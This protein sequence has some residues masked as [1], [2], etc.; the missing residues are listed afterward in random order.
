MAVF[1]FS[2]WSSAGSFRL[3]PVYFILNFL[4]MISESET[5]ESLCSDAT[6]PPSPV[7]KWF[8]SVDYLFTVIYSVSANGGDVVPYVRVSHT[9][10]TCRRKSSDAVFVLP[11]LR[12]SHL[13]VSEF[14]FRSGA[15]RNLRSRTALDNL[16]QI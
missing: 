10:G 12:S 16:P 6:P 4:Y 1:F 9:F 13:Y 3:V 8:H 15:N 2:S 14:T 11:V 5:G 7:F